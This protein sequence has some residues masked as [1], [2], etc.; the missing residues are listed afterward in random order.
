M[1]TIATH[2]AKTHL[3]RYLNEVSEGKS[4]IISRGR[5]PMAKLVPITEGHTSARPKVGETMDAPMHVPVGDLSPL[6]DTELVEW[7]I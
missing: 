1:K 7:G 5:T 2:E 3:S 4:F 6:S